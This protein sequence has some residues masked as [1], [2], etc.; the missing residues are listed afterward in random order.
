MERKDV[1]PVGTDTSAMIFTPGVQ[2]GN[3]L[4]TS[5]SVGAKEG[6][7]AGDDIASQSRQAL[8]NLG[9]VLDAAGTSF[10][11]VIKLNCFLAH[12]KRD[13]GGWN[14]V[15]KEFFPNK[16]PARTTIGGPAAMEGALIEIE[17]VALVP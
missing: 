4:F 13:F 15:Y 2:V 5:G 3:L 16:P 12:P 11:N 6:V 14:A 8:E 1:I 17:L 9:L 7:L 10:A